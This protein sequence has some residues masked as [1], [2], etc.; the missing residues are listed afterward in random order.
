MITQDRYGRALSPDAVER[1]LADGTFEY[2][3]AIRIYDMQGLPAT[4]AAW[5]PYQLDERCLR[6]D[7]SRTFRLDGSGGCHLQ[8]IADLLPDDAPIEQYHRIEIDMVI[9]GFPPQE[10]PW[11]TGQLEVIDTDDVLED[12]GSTT[13]TIEVEC[14]DV[15]KRAD[16]R[17]IDRFRVVPAN[18][19]HVDR[20]V[21]ICPKRRMKVTAVVGMAGTEAVPFALSYDIVNTIV[22][23]PNSDMSGAYTRGD[24]TNGYTISAAA[25]PATVTWGSAR[26]P[27]EPRWIEVPVPERFGIP[28]VSG[29]PRFLVL[30]YGREPDD[31]MQTAIGAYTAGGS[32]KITPSDPTSYKTLLDTSQGEWL[33]VRSSATGIVETK[34]INSVDAGT[35]ELTLASAFSTIT[36]AVGDAIWLSTTELYPTWLGDYSQDIIY[37]K[38]SAQTVKHKRAAFRTLPN[39][40]LAVAE[41][42]YDF[43]GSTSDSVYSTIQRGK[44]ESEDSSSGV[45]SVVKTLL[46]T[47]TSLFSGGDV[48]ATNSGAAIKCI[49]AHDMTLGDLLRQLK[50]RAMPPNSYIRATVAG[51]VTIGPVQQ[52]TSPDWVLRF[53]ESLRQKARP[54]PFSAVVVMARDREENRAAVWYNHALTSNVTN[55]TRV[56][57]GDTQLPATQTAAGSPIKVGF[58]IP[59]PTPTETYPNIKQ[60]EVT[61]TGVLTI[62]G[63]QDPEGSAA[64]KYPQALVRLVVGG[65]QGANA[66]TGTLT[67]SPEDLLPLLVSTKATDV[68]F[69]M[70]ELD[71]SGTVAP[72]ITEIKIIVKNM[73][74]WRAALTDGASGMP[75]GWQ[76]ADATQFGTIWAQPDST[77]LES[78]RFAPQSYAQRV[79]VFWSGGSRSGQKHRTKTLE[80]DGISQQDARDIAES[81]LDEEVRVATQ[82]EVTGFIP[83][84]AEPAD[85]VQVYAPPG[86]SFRDG[87]GVKNLFLWEFGGDAYGSLTLVDYS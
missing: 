81:Y 55:P 25:I 15:L 65:A 45:E 71:T 31:L 8:I 75:T 82:Y 36:P 50:D 11:F 6:Q 12:D 56:I 61:G 68:I 22:I 52:Q 10:W 33:S 49:Y 86:R 23:S 40:G 46:T 30:P 20:L 9:P 17:W 28:V 58:R 76:P 67:I 66:T 84:W 64:T 48:S 34:Q 4:A 43:T 41:L 42:P 7:P 24:A 60:I 3:W 73:M 1:A 57:D 62:Y 19:T 16:G 54:E 87:K 44:L 21:G 13:R 77:K 80:L 2:S 74:A 37:Y 35:G 18:T 27:A 14:L 83:P 59:A 70:D 5:V 69:Q 63:V 53:T 39:A 78:Y 38:D 72:A 51:T 26:D 79:L 29:V 47:T 85:T 32:P